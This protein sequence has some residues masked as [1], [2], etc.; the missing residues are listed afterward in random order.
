MA[1]ARFIRP[2]FFTD[3]KVSDLPFG[4]ALLFCGIW[5][6]S[7]LRGV[8]EC[9]PR[10]LRGLIFP[11]RDGIE[12]ATISEWLALLEKN[13]MT[14]RFEADGKSWGYVCKW[15][16]YQQVSGRERDLGSR[17]PCPPTCKGHAEDTLGTRLEHACAASPSPTPTPTEREGDVVHARTPDQDRREHLEELGAI[18]DRA[19]VD[20]YPEWK[21]ATKGMK[22]PM[23]EDIFKAAKPG[24]TWPSEFK[25]HRE[26]RGI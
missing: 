2:E 14:G 13:G 19:G 17:R 25:K 12:T 22:A 15:Q 23:V 6:H 24:I 11:M 5:C 20:I 3:E 21:A 7:D 26:V 10:I 16:L 1:R 4:A 9:S 8:F 18:M